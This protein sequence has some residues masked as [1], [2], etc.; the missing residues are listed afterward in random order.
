MRSSWERRKDVDM[1]VSS[2][3]HLREKIVARLLDRENLNID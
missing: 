3:H 2:C 1:R